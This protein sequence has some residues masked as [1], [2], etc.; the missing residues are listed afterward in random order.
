MK[1]KLFINSICEKC[2]HIDVCASIK[3]NR[4]KCGCYLEERQHGEWIHEYDDFYHCSICGD[5]ICTQ[6]DE[7]SLKKNFPFC[8]CGADM[9]VKT[10]F[11]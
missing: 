10:D 9:R 8:H 2:A 11:N 7:L 6:W 5:V 1:D 4:Q 3:D